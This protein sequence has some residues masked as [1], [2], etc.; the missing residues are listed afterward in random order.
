MKFFWLCIFLCCSC[1]VEL[2]I[3][4]AKV[5]P[6]WTYFIM[7]VVN[8]SCTFLVRYNF[9]SSNSTLSSGV[10]WSVC[11]LSVVSHRFSWDHALK[12]P[13]PKQPFYVF[14]TLLCVCND[15]RA[16]QQTSQCQTQWFSRYYAVNG[17]FLNQTG[18][19]LFWHVYSFTWTVLDLNVTE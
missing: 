16:K 12:W 7:Y 10:Q 1:M 13:N 17:S 9:Y 15:L 5:S 6:N 11:F 8:V 19:L 18:S 14:V 4:T 2:R 3:K